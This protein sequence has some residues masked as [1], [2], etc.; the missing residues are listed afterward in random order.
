[1]LHSGIFRA[2]SKGIKLAAKIVSEKF[3]K[4]FFV[5]RKF[6]KQMLWARANVKLKNVSSATMISRLVTEQLTEHV[7]KCQGYNEICAPVEY[8]G[9]REGSAFNTRW[10]DFT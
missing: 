4:L 3:I 5:S 8:S 2:T 9:D 7:Q 10:E 1:M 6:P